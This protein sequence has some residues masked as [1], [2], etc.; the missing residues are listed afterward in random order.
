MA[1]DGII[2][3][4]ITRELRE[5]IT[6]GKIE[7]V[8][9]PGN[10]ELVLQIHTREGNVRLFA[11]CNSQ[12][13]RL[14]LTNN[15]YKN[16]DQPPTFC[17][18]LRKHL[19]GGR[20][21][22]VRQYQ[23][24]RIIEIDIEAQNEL[25]FTVSRRLIIEIMGKHSNIVLVDISSGK[26]IDSIKRI[27]IDVNRYRQLLPGVI[28]KYPPA[29]D[30]IPFK[31]VA[32]DTELP[33]EAK[34]LA[35]AVGGI[36]PAIARELLFDENISPYVTLSGILQSIEEGTCRGRVYLDDNGAP[37]EFHLTD[38][39]EY[40][41]VGI[42]E[43]DNLSECVEYYFFNRESSNMVKQKSIPLQKTVQ[44]ALDKAL[45][46]RKKLGEDLLAAENSDRY[47]LYGELLTANIHMVQAGAKSVSVPNYYDGNPITIPLDEKLSASKNA[48][49]YFKK[50]S[51]AKTAIHEKQAQL[52]DNDKDILYLESVLHSVN[53][54]STEEELELIR[55]E[56]QETGYVRFRNKPGMR[57]KKNKPTPIEYRL[58]DGT[59]VLVGRNN[60]EN[61]WLTMKY[62]SKVDV[63]MHTKDIPGS[64]VILRL[65]DGRTVDD[66]PA[67]II[68]EAASIA[69]YHSKAQ[70]SSQVP[71]DYVPVRYIK[72]PNGS[73]PGYVIF[74]HNMTVYVDP[75]LPEEK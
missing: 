65:D 75:K 41:G 1:F 69:A 19:Q 27:S 47:R 53:S 74:T 4:G 8:Y 42:M 25:G 40:D 9:Q 54:S 67:D 58:A 31:E 57:K 10:E 22:D 49:R 16:P 34:L 39:H 18:L 45:L 70:N 48:Q 36:S 60:N 59:Q 32:A 23:S 68:Y 37:K 29:Q 62:A 12:S 7:K 33:S 38:L 15:R 17:M 2:T 71:V 11:S 66:L 26:I 6:L 30:K 63:W 35:M 52:E 55:E 50:Y 28:Y 73:K 43:F 3:Y 24:E 46:K 13:A 21:T 72:K 14:C 5:R 20:I 56:L 51:K 64:H 44:T 61:D